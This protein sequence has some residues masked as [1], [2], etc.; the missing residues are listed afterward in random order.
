MGLWSTPPSHT[1]VHSP[2]CKKASDQMA[3][4]SDQRQGEHM[5]TARCAKVRLINSAGASDQF[6]GVP[7]DQLGA[8][9]QIRV[10]AF[11]GCSLSEGARCRKV[12]DFGRCSVDK[13]AG[14]GLLVW[15]TS[16]GRRPAVN[17]VCLSVRERLS[18]SAHFSSF[19]VPRFPQTL[20]QSEHFSF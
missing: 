20:S 13:A 15:F 9:D 8:S 5:C 2:I 4:A 12:Q 11:G 17:R 14:G 6:G 19:A 3:R 10:L 7:S 18:G 1:Y 16:P